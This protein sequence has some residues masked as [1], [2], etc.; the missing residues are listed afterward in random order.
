MS[1]IS[2][3]IQ[4]DKKLSQLF[5]RAGARSFIAVGRALDEVGGKTRTQVIKAT[6]KQTGVKQARVRQVIKTKRALGAGA[7]E[8][9]IIARDVMLSRKEFA[10]RKT[11]KGVSVTTAKRGR[12]VLAH[13]WFGPGSHVFV[14]QGRARLPVKK[15]YAT[16]IPNEMVKNEAEATFYRNVDKLFGA[17]VEKHL[18]R[19]LEGK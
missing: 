7:G 4:F 6:A 19:A 5:E 17:A 14:R 12:I 8:Y 3:S 16:A 1:G 2:I 9:K 11:P 18:L 13:S 15:L 10:P